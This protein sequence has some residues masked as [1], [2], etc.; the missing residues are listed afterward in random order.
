MCL[1]CLYQFEKKGNKQ[2]LDIAQP[3]VDKALP[4]VVAPSQS[5]KPVGL[6]A[7]NHSTKTNSK[8][9]KFLSILI[10]VLYSLLS[11]LLIQNL[12]IV[13][14]HSCEKWALQFDRANFRN[15][16]RSVSFPLNSTLLNLYRTIYLL[17]ESLIFKNINKSINI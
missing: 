14:S 6:Y 3:F 16:Q 7:V 15:G 5:R 8:I 12:N 2:Q 9:C 17:K 10:C 1:T 11:T 4:L 13:T